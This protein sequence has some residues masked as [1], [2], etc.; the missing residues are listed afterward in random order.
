VEG[1]REVVEDE[2]DLVGFRG[3]FDERLSTAAIRT[4]Q[5]LEYDDS[6]A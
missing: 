6:D 4:L 5:V 1:Q 3:L 2:R